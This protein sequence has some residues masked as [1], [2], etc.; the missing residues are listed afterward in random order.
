MTTY[1]KKTKQWLWHAFVSQL[2][3]FVAIFQLLHWSQWIMYKKFEW[4]SSYHGNPKPSFLGVITPIL[5]VWNRHFSW[6][7][8]PRVLNMS[9]PKK[10]KRLGHLL[11]ARKICAIHPFV[12]SQSSFG[13]FVSIITPSLP[14]NPRFLRAKRPVDASNTLHHVCC[15]GLGTFRW[16]FFVGQFVFSQG[17]WGGFKQNKSFTHRNLEE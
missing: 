9:S 10:I 17:P 1:A 4:Y 8:G 2:K 12:V 6:F 16:F 7:W 13:V 3:F 5:G 14:E 15:A 11:F